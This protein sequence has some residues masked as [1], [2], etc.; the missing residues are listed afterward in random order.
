MQRRLLLSYLTITLLVLLLLEIPLG[1]SYARAERRRL[2]TAVQHDALALAFRAEDRI[3]AGDVAALQ[4]IAREG[5]R[6]VGGRVVIVDRRGAVLADSEPPSRAALDRPLTNAP[7][8]RAA[9][10]GREVTGTRHVDTLGG[11]F[12]SVAEPIGIST[13]GVGAAATAATI[14]GVV[15]VSYPLSVIDARIRDNWLLLAGIGVAVLAVVFVVSLTLARSVTRPV[16]ELESAADQLGRGDL[17]ARAAVAGHPPELRVLAQS[18]NRTASHLEQL[19]HSQQAFIAD[20]SH[21]LR[22][23]LAAL[24]LRLENVQHEAGTT[25]S[26]WVEDLD[27]ALAEVARL[28]RIVD[29]LLEL[30]HAERQAPAPEDVDVGDVVRRREAAWSAFAAE[31][32]VRIDVTIEGRCIARV[33]PG[34]LEQVLDNLLNNAVEVAPAHTDVSLSARDDGNWVVVDVADAGPG[35]SEAA[36][37]RAF[38]RF[39]RETGQTRNVGSGL[40]LAIVQHL[41]RSDAGTVA[42]ARSSQGGLQ[43][44]V[45]LPAAGQP[46]GRRDQE[47]AA[48][49]GRRW[50]T[51]VRPAK[52]ANV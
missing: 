39:W 27:G 17:S 48:A 15:R 46:G 2:T 6:R 29:G 28:S 12:L 9:L 41:V 47:P 33:T 25:A 8:I 10:S 52:S 21:Q 49:S 3:E 32:E 36:M 34:R 18:F 43:V 30:A 31:R 42:L 50:P 14:G 7:D 45:R 23:P 1:V 4:A 35:M 5:R 20:A 22:T 11:D 40:G 19:V 24:R 38:D 37:A 51:R 16:R 26:V 13:S 44:T